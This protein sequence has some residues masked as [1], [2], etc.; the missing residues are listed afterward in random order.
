MLKNITR[1]V[2]II[3]IIVLQT[4][5]FQYLNINNVSPNLF[6]I[7]IVSLSALQGRKE[8]LIFALA[9][10]LVQDIL[11]GN[12]VG[13]YVLI[14][15]LIAALAG[16]LYQNY[17]TENIV[18]PLVAMGIGDL[19]YNVLIFFFTFLLRGKINIGYYIFNIIF[20]EITYTVFIAVLLYRVYMIYSR[21][22]HEY[23]KEKRKGD[24]DFYERDL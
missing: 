7:T 11:F 15:M 22:I 14:Y 1:G 4:T 10:G 23:E 21:L 18:I 2:I 17:Y 5:L 19:I 13:F 16:Y 12:I 3:M 8:G 20:P 6:I 9:F 24:D